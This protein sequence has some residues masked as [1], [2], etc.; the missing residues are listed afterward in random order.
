[1]QIK[2]EFINPFLEA[3]TI[4]FKEILHAEMI[5]G[6][7]GIKESPTPSYELA[8]L[9]GIVGSFSGEVV[10]SMNLDTAYKISRKLVPDI[11]DADMPNEYRDILGEIANMIT[12]NAMNIFT[13]TGQSVDITTPNIV[14][15]A[16]STLKYEKKP[17]LSINLYT[18]MG[19]FEV[20]V[21]LT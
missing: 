5:R 21:A 2:A 18:K 11:A 6:K 9:I 15:V 14:E 1:M 16:N 7:I 4:V 20:N 13:T 3:S 10:F 12:G 8:I 19:R 17:S